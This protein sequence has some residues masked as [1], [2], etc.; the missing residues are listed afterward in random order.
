MRSLDHVVMP[1]RKISHA[2]DW[3]ETL[4][5][6]VAPEAQHPFGTGNACVYLEDGLMIE[7][8]SVVDP[9]ACETAITEGNL[10]VLR[11][12]AFRSSLSSAFSGLALQSRDGLEDRNALDAFGLAESRTTEFERRLTL[13]NG[14]V[15]ELSFRLVFVKDFAPE[16]PNVFLC[17]ARHAVTIDRSRLTTHGNTARGIAAVEF[18]TTDI[19]SAR[20]YL[21]AVLNADGQDRDDGMVSFRLPNGEVE[22]VEVGGDGAAPFALTAMTVVVADRDALTSVFARNGVSSAVDEEG[23]IL[24]GCPNG[25]GE[26]RF[27]EENRA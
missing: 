17:E 1:F 18:S 25:A 13:P 15:A 19:E 14:D 3:F 26:I 12:R 22:L 10:F 11:D 21:G 5:F 16:A 27:I 2:R 9:L 8:L 24:V 20:S 23:S 4:G 6:T 7:P